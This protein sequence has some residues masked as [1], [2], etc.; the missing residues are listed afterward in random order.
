MNENDIN[1]FDETD[2]AD[3]R[4]S[5]MAGAASKSVSLDVP[6]HLQYSADHVWVDDADGLAVIGLTEYAASQMGEIV[7]VDLPEPDTPVRAGDE[8][9]E[10]ESA[11]T[12]QN[13]IS[14]VEGTVKYV[15]QAVADDP[16]VIN[17][18]PYGEGWIL[19]IE[20]DDDEPELMDA[21][22]YAAMVKR[23]E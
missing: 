18:D 6:D 3:T 4:D 13:L 9:V 10:M 16:Q 15:N 20:M 7:Y 14:P 23:A 2:K 21:D 22:Q 1:E 8:I 11:K 17:N 12:V 19:K 5:G